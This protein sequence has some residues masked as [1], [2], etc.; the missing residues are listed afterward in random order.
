MQTQICPHRQLHAHPGT[1][2][3]TQGQELLDTPTWGQG[4][5]LLA[6]A[7]WSSGWDTPTGDQEQGDQSMHVPTHRVTQR[8]CHTQGQGGVTVTHTGK[9][10][11]ACMHAHRA[12]AHSPHNY[13][14]PC[15]SQAHTCSHVPS[16]EVIIACRDSCCHLNTNAATQLSNKYFLDSYCGTLMFYRKQNLCS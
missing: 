3:Q 2:R 15:H 9:V 1:P 8:C 7:L 5:R 13:K 10:T 14:R 6:D 16:H 12:F 4:K 11:I